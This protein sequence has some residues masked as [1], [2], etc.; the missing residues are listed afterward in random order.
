MTDIQALHGYGL[1]YHQTRP[2]AAAGHD[3]VE[4][5]AYLVDAHRAAPAIESALSRVSGLGPRRVEMV[6]A[7]VDSWR[8][9]AE[10]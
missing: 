1:T 6:C 5:V 3:T 10:P 7:A 8:A 2:L 4:R 9:R